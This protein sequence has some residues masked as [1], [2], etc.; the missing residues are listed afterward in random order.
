M[1][2]DIRCELSGCAVTGSSAHVG[3]VTDKASRVGTLKSNFFNMN[4]F[5]GMINKVAV[6]EKITALVAPLFFITERSQLW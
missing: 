5:P 6:L 3:V 1:G 2:A 4:V